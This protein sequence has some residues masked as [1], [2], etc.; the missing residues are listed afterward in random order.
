[1]SVEILDERSLFEKLMNHFGWYKTQ[2]SDVKIDRLEVDYRFIMDLPEELKN[3][4]NQEQVTKS[5]RQEHR[6]RNQGRQTPKTSSSNRPI[7]QTSSRK[8]ESE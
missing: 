4:I 1:M 6:S 7:R 2:M 5:S 3:A 8:K